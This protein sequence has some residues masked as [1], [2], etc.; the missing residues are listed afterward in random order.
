[1][2]EADMDNAS[3]QNL[4]NLQATAKQYVDSVSGELAQVCAE[5]AKGRGCD[6]PGI[7]KP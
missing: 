2:A 7:G 4:E 5:L 6:M 1:L 3:P